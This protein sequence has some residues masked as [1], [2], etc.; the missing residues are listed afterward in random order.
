MS[1]L[2]PALKQLINA[3]FAKPSYTVVNPST[4]T[5]TISKLASEAR[6]HGVSTPA[7]LT[8]S[9]A[10]A[11]TMNAPSAM[12]LL[13]DTAQKQDRSLNPVL[14][15]ELQREVG[16]KCIS[17]NGIPRSINCLGAFYSA[18]PEDVRTKLS[19]KPTRE[20]KT[21]NIEQRK[22]DGLGLWDS[23]Y[24]GFERKLLSKLGQS[25]PDLPV[26]IIHGHYASLL[27]NPS[28]HTY[29]DG[30]EK[31]RET[32]VGRVLTSLV[33]IACLRAQTGVGP[34]VVSH[35]FGLRKAYER[36]D[37][38][39]EGEVEVQGGKWLS[40]EEGNAWLLGWIDE[41]VKGIGT[42]QEGDAEMTQSSGGT[43][44]APGLGKAKL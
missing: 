5:P 4:L 30:E 16:L 6:D 17:F 12:T 19:N 41:L 43:S 11:M 7:W 15:A 44:F 24:Y 40:S 37:A 32:H 14:T 34:Q 36:G 13:W 26:H 29:V 35:V 23:V 20:F 1:K 31:P 8:F 38:E 42:M 39:A 3:P 2:S 27:S 33:A 9:T 10:T 18:L 25:H 22:N 21:D 28:R